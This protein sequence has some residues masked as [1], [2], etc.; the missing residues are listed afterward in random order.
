MIRYPKFG[1]STADLIT[2]LR[3]NL[4]LLGRTDFYVSIER[5]EVG[6]GRNDSKELTVRSNGSTIIQDIMTEDSFTLYIFIN[7]A[8]ETIAKKELNKAVTDV[9]SAL[10][11]VPANSKRIK[12]VTDLSSSEVGVLGDTLVGSILLNALSVAEEIIE[13]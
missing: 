3:D 1:D 9:F 4:I 5:R 12:A 13:L 11:L 2:S 7:N 8:N 10:K 6:E